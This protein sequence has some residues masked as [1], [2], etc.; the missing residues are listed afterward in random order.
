MKKINY[1]FLLI[2]PV[3]FILLQ[4]YYKINYGPLYLKM[5]DPEY[6]YLLN[7]L[8]LNNFKLDLD[9]V[10]HPG[11][12]VQVISALTN[13]VVHI[14]RGGNSLTDDVLLH[15][16]IYLT[17]TQVS[18]TL[19]N[20]F[21]IL[22]AGLLLFRATGK[23]FYAVAFQFAP[24]AH[25]LTVGIANRVLPESLLVGLSVLF[26]AYAVYYLL[27]Q[28]QHETDKRKHVTRFS[29]LSG[30]ALATKITFVPVLLIPLMLLKGKPAKL[31]FVLYTTAAFLV[32]AFPLITKLSY[33][34]RWM[35][36]L[37]LH[38]GSHG[39]GQAN[40]IDWTVFIRNLKYI[41]SMFP[42]IYW[43]AGI[44]FVFILLTSFKKIRNKIT[45]KQGF[46][47]FLALFLNILLQVIFSAKSYSDKYLAPSL[48]ESFI[49]ILLVIYFISSSGFINKYKQWITYLSLPVLIILFA[50]PSGKRIINYNETLKK[51]KNAYLH[52]R[53]IITQIPADNRIIF[54]EYG[55]AVP[56]WS[57]WY[58]SLFTGRYKAWITRSLEKLYPN[59]YFYDVN[60]D[61]IYHYIDKVT[62]SEI[63]SLPGRTILYYKTF[64]PG[65]RSKIAAYFEKNF[66]FE[67]VKKF[68]KTGEFVYYLHKKE[69][70]SPQENTTQ[71]LK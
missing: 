41:H 19:I 14:F 63:T 39:S 2:I 62:P 67:P 11:T 43:S 9:Y 44:L 59:T 29:L 46:I 68:E 10:D 15:P 21:L 61:K 51:D 13:F 30:L 54:T 64:V 4:V 35:V 3:L 34:S 52:T 18:L 38:S 12:P 37:F 42:G 23:M 50:I 49:S 28:Q 56:E 20:A 25:E 70:S 32:F 24:L 58:G 66:S 31:K 65:F 7:G 55:C 40:V 47:F 53:N 60:Q 57:L 8:C 17:A 1:S 22:L 5:A 6:A 33:F 36:A 45:G 27:K 26:F 69:V 16:E 71:N 48:I